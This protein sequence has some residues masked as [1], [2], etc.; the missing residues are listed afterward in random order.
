MNKCQKNI[1]FC[2]LL[3]NKTGQAGYDKQKHYWYYC[4]SYLKHSW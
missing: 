2:L 4:D 3:I 1:Y